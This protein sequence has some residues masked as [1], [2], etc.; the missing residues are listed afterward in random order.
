MAHHVLCFKINK[1]TLPKIYQYFTIQQEN[2]LV[3]NLEQ[4]FE[5][6]GTNTI[7]M[8]ILHLKFGNDMISIYYIPTR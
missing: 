1:W 4:L 6:D 8:I 5:R 2:V 3:I 7:D